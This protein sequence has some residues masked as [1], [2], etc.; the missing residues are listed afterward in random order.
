[1]EKKKSKGKL[2]ALI[3]AIVV[4]VG[5]VTTGIVLAATGTL[6]GSTKE[7]AFDL[8]KQAPEKMTQSAVSKQLGLDELSKAMLEKGM[9]INYKIKDIQS[10]DSSV[11]LSGMEMGAGLSL[12]VNNKKASAKIALSKDGS[13][14][15]AEAYGSLEEKKAAFSLPELIPNKTFS[16]T[17]SDN[18]SQEALNSISAVLAVL[19]DLQET[20][21]DFLEE[22]G[23]ALYDSTECEKVDNGYQIKITKV[24]L[25][26]FVNKFRDYVSSQSETLGKIEE[27]L[28]MSKGTIA[29]GVGMIVPQ[30]TSYTQDIIVTV[31][32]TD[33]NLTGF[34]TSVTVAGVKLDI[35]GAFVD[36]D[37]Q[38]T[39]NVELSLAQNGS[40][41]GTVTY[42]LQGKKGDVCED[43]IKMVVSS[44]GTE[45]A[46]TEVKESLDTKNNNA[47]T[48]SASVKSYNSD[49]VKM[50][51]SGSVKNLEK[52]KSIT[53]DFKDV[54]VDQS[55]TGTNTF[56]MEYSF[57]ALDG[58]VKM[59]AGEEQVVT[60]DTLQSTLTQYQS[61]VMTNLQNILGKW[62]ISDISS[63]FSPSS[64]DPLGLSDADTSLTTDSY[65]G[66]DDDGYTDSYDDSYT[67]SYE[68][69]NDTL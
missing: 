36:N 21:S 39:A 29:S 33:G 45:I 28:G 23:D 59:P 50:S 10:S 4:V 30:I 67:D 64:S 46:S 19:P 35:H 37:A 31:E 49:E 11:D 63:L 32:G 53:L 2:I 38:N 14:L 17:A 13:Q 24:S 40:S 7:K 44:M 52:G 6:F 27:K 66:S 65:D 57:A 56:G 3:I 20:F 25:D 55:E 43:T 26:E 58:E 9:D 41:I 8:L 15:S 16:I 61:D 51:C 5:V 1:M 12:D 62:G 47:L 54:S 68:D 22:Q 42:N 18:E 60:A 48:M 34:K 69:E